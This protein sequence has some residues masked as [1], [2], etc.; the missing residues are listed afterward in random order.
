VGAASIFFPARQAVEVAG[1]S[2]EGGSSSRREIGADERARSGK[3]APARFVEFSALVAGGPVALPVADEVDLADVGQGL[4]EDR[5]ETGSGF[6]TT[7][8]VRR[9]C[10][11][12]LS[13][14]F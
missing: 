14:V 10:P 8:S 13:Q 1:T 4:V 7:Y 6:L 11:T 2:Q 5:E 9:P 3:E 12:R